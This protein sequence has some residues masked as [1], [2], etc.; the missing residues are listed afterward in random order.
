MLVIAALLGTRQLL[1]GLLALMVR[2]GLLLGLANVGGW[3]VNV[4][5]PVLMSTV[6]D[7][8]AVLLVTGFS[9]A[10]L[11]GALT[12]TLA[13][14]RGENDEVRRSR[15]RIEFLASHDALTGLP[16]RLLARDRFEQAAATARRCGGKV[17]CCT[18]TWVVSAPSTTR[19]ATRPATS[20]CA[21]WASGCARC[22]APATPSAAPAATN[23]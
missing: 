23:S 11:S 7:A 3:Y 1:G 17:G 14:L 20:C 12:R 4:V 2:S 19:W 18:W 22:C 13:R 16:K 6:I 5:Q 9:V 21:G 15:D 8:V 10:L